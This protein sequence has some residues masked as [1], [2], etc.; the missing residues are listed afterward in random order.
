MVPSR[1]GSKGVRG[2]RVAITSCGEEFYADF[3]IPKVGKAPRREYAPEL[4]FEVG[5][6]RFTHAEGDRRADVAGDRVSD[7]VSELRRVLM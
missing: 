3:L 1:E 4:L 5:G 7:L 6:V 2:E